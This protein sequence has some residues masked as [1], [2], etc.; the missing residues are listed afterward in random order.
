MN[1]LEQRALERLK[2]YVHN[3]KL[4]IDT[5][6]LLAE[7]ANQF[8]G[9]VIPLLS[10]EKNK[11]IIPFRCLQE[12]QK[13]AQNPQN[14][15]LSGRAKSVQ[16]CLEQLKKEHY[17]EIRGEASD[18][19]LA[20]NVFSTVFTKFRMNYNLLLIT[21]DKGLAADIKALNNSRSVRC[22]DCFA[23]RINSFGYLSPISD[24]PE[25]NVTNDVKEE[26]KFQI[27][28]QVTDISNEPMGTESVR[29]GDSLKSLV[30][31]ILIQNK[32]G[33]GGE[34]TVY[35][36]NTD[37][38]AKIYFPN[39]N[40]P[41]RKEKIQ[42][43]LAHPIQYPGICWPV[44]WLQNQQGQFVGYLMPRAKGL[45][46][47]EKLF[48]SPKSKY[49]P[50]N[51][52]KHDIV[53]LC[54]EILERIRYL[55]HRN[56]LLGDLQPDNIVV[57]ETPEEV[58][59]VDTDSYQIEGFP[60]GVGRDSFTAPE[61]HGKHFELFLRTPE[62]ERFA[63]AVL[64]FMCMLPGKHPYTCTNGGT[65]SDNIQAQHFPYP[66]GDQ[67]SDRIPQGRWRYA[68]SHLPHDIKGS[69]W[70]TFHK[71]GKYF[72]PAKRLSADQWL[73]KFQ[74][75]F[76]LLISGKLTEQDPMAD[77]I[78]PTRLKRES[79][80]KYINCKICGKEIKE[81]WAKFGMCNDCANQGEIISCSRCHHNFIYTNFAQEQNKQKGKSEWNL[82]CP[83]CVDEAQHV[84]D[85]AFC[86]KCQEPFDVSYREKFVK[87]DIPTLCKKCRFQLRESGDDV[88]E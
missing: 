53:K 65:G 80:V 32:L 78:L 18:S 48:S 34:G 39:R 82:L 60:S 74:K 76:E 12:I 50:L 28:D 84:A 61:I 25:W 63:L 1:N 66:F 38:V 77:D 3:Y 4:F 59:F 37:Y 40:T 41:R 73:K 30:G 11:I 58:F 55:H 6:S 85:I 31:D 49:F 21:Q 19:P 52:K 33:D 46:L 24:N 56:V 8:W 72:A 86:S 70:H 20:D 9:H 51:W 44:S 15:D 5:S 22:K 36:T 42:R 17:I 68:W 13:H 79:G 69:F 29:E 83:H 64:L 10:Q 14:P 67:H 54:I 16:I 7:N 75:Y 43:M 35:E 47:N 23:M 88:T 87:K 81:E 62:Q 71:K 2:N 57:G 27:T 26:F 45:T